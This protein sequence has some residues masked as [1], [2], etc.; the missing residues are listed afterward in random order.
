[1]DSM[2]R[3]IVA[4]ITTVI[5]WGMWVLLMN[6]RRLDRF[7]EIKAAFWHAAEDMMHSDFENYISK[8]IIW[9]CKKTGKKSYKVYAVEDGLVKDLDKG[10]PGY[11]LI[12]KTME[13]HISEW[14]I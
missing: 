4:L 3:L 10:I 2:D 9:L 1:M 11:T 12:C 14:Y 6:K 7:M 13:G 5:M 8:D